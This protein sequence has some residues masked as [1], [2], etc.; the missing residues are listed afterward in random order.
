MFFYMSVVWGYFNENI[1]YIIYLT[2]I[3]FFII[4]C[5]KFFIFLNNCK[6]DYDKSNIVLYF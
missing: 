6:M 5:F 3:L 2:K 4:K 1:F